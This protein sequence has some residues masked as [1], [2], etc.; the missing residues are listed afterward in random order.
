M[1]EVAARY[2]SLD[3]LRPVC[4]SLSAAVSHSSNRSP[5]MKILISDRK[6]ASK[7]SN[8]SWGRNARR[9]RAMVAACPSP[10]IASSSGALLLAENMR[11]SEKRN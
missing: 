10:A 2:Q 4:N 9:K 3:A 11:L 8:V 5:V 6:M 7:A 1:P